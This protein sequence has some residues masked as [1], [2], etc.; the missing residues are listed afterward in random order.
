MDLI[1]K[2]VEEYSRNK[3]WKTL[4]LF[5]DIIAD[6]LSNTKANPMVTELLIRGRRINISLV[7]IT[8][9]YFGV[10]K[11]ITLSSTHCFIMKI[12]NKRELQQITFKVG[13]SPLKKVAL[14]A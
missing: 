5:D 3:E 10:S 4:I 7:F 13:L 6:M 1:Y 8:Q 9:N 14:F 12:W 2:I 11:N